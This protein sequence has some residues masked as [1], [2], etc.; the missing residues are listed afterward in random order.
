VRRDVDTADA[1]LL[2]A[3]VL[4]MSSASMSASAETV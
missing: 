3:P 2:V 4:K 1:D